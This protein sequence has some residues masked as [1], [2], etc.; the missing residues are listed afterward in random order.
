MRHALI[1]GFG[2][3][4]RSAANLLL[5]KGFN[6]TA[7]D[8]RKQ[9][10]F[11]LDEVQD[12][13][14]KGV[15]LIDERTRLP[16]HD[17]AICSP[18]IPS[19]HP[20]LRHCKEVISEVELAFRYIHQPV[21]GISGTNGKTTVTLLVEHILNQS[22]KKARALGN[23][24]IPLTSAID[25]L[26][27][28]EIVVAEL[29][30]YQLE[31]LHDPILEAAVL[32]NITPD[33]LDRYGTME[34]YAEAKLKLQTITKNKAKFFIHEAYHYLSPAS[35]CYG[36]NKTAQLRTDLKNLYFERMDRGLLPTELQVKSH[37]LE[38]FMAAYFLCHTLGIDHA[39]I[40]AAYATFSKPSHRIELVAEI[41]GIKY[42]DDSKGTNVDAVMR[43]VERMEGPVHLIVGGVDKGASYSPWLKIFKNRVISIHAIGE[44]AQ[45]IQKELMPFD[46]QIC[47]D[48][49]E[50]FQCAK[51]RA[52]K[53][54]SVL[55]SP[56]CSSFD[57]FKDYKERG[58]AFQALVKNL[59]S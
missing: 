36:Y 51:G 52:V 49:A 47:K 45:K 20:L 40:V 12:L 42:F 19:S 33:H 3:S 29:S 41:K 13:L 9:E 57:M 50:A 7:V 10:I 23:V 15:E 8:A 24:G 54:D 46:V 5:S 55:L 38:N 48:L 27:S 18:G 26:D 6:V 53:G 56:G 1:I 35:S 43:A 59:L 22:G 32:L 17:F 2:L 16:E 25:T 34:K 21:I 30:S 4:G 14:E 31:G 11:L 39:S 44:A 37:D 28:D 58:K